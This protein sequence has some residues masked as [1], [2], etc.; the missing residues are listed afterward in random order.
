[1]LLCL[2]QE[3]IASIAWNSLLDTIKHI[4]NPISFKRKIKSIKT[5]CMSGTSASKRNAL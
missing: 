4:E 1:M 3:P 2:G 5:Y